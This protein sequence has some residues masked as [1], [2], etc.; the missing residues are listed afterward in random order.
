MPQPAKTS[1]TVLLAVLCDGVAAF[2]VYL[3][4]DVLRSFV[5]MRTAWPEHVEGQGS[6]FTMHLTVAALLAVAWP[7]LLAWHRWYRPIEMP[8]S[9]ILSRMLFATFLAAMFIGAASLLYERDVY[10]RAQIVFVAVLLP[11]VTLAV[12]RFT[13]PRFIRKQIRGKTPPTVRPP[14][15][16]VH[17]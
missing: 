9:W 17:R 15:Q 3:A 13:A 10:P 2:V 4:A 16:L 11:L 7:V 14:V 6:M 8:R 12:R 1:R 5:Y